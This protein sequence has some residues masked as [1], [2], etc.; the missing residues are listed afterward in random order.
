MVEKK[1]SGK[2]RQQSGQQLTAL[3]SSLGAG[4]SETQDASGLAAVLEVARCPL[5]SAL[6][7]RA[8]GL[9]SLLQLWQAEF[10]ASESVLPLVP[11][12]DDIEQKH[13]LNLLTLGA[14][15]FQRV[16]TRGVAHFD[17]S[18]HVVLGRDLREHFLVELVDSGAALV[19]HIERLVVLLGLVDCLT[20][21]LVLSVRVGLGLGKKKQLV[22]V[23]GFVALPHGTR[24]V[25]API[26][27]RVSVSVLVDVR[28]LP[29]VPVSVRVSF[30]RSRL[31]EPLV[32]RRCV[33]DDQV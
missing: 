7:E 6:G 31:L 16:L 20:L 28:G 14:D 5:V 8:R 21:F 25:R 2:H 9:Y 12:M 19:L 24:K 15:V 4:V 30:G 17:H 13:H 3:D 10:L 11:H 26:L 27:G 29:D 22:L 32:L 23:G 33:V 18:H 1:R